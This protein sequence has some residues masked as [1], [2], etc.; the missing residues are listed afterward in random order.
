VRRLHVEPRPGWRE[1]VEAQGLV[2]H[3]TSDGREYWRE[4]A[5]YAFT[6]AEI[7]AI[8]RATNDIHAL[9]L[10]AA[11][12]VVERGGLVELGVPLHAVALVERSFRAA[13]ASLYG[14]LDLALVDGVPKL[15]EYNAD[16][17]TSLLEAAVIQWTW[18]E[19]RRL[20]GDQFNRIHDALIDRWRKLA[21]PKVWFASLDD[22]EDRVTVA[23]L[24]DT[25]AQAGVVTAGLDVTDIGWDNGFIDVD[26]ARIDAL[27]KLYPWEALWAEAT[28]PLVPKDTATTWL[29]PAWKMLWSTKALLPILWELFPD[30]PNLLPASRE[31]LAGPFVKKPIHGREGSNVTIRAPGVDVDTGGPYGEAGFVYQ[32]YVDLGAFDGMRPVIGSWLVGG[33]SVGIGVREIEG[34]VTT[35]TASFVPHVVE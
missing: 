14:R 27:F 9:C 22:V 6:G 29:E 3:A 20:G 28:F 30:H 4:D 34:Y 21:L 24:R 8:E 33:R 15:L 16:T 12:V 18:L 7:D 26:R 11:R 31:P 13:E 2:F 23:Y 25:A 17:P 19:D 1:R 32:R 10:E 35:N 5:C